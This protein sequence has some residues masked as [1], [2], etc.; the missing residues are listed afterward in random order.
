MEVSFKLLL[1][2]YYL[3]LHNIPEALGMEELPDDG[4]LRLE[5]S[6]RHSRY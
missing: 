6:I 2:D 5:Q 3:L 1:R 4:N